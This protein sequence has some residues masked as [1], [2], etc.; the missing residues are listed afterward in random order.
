MNL[1][2]PGSLGLIACPGGE[3]FAN[4][5]LTSL[6]HIYKK[7]LLKKASS[8]AK[9]YG[10][11]KEDV[12]T[13]INFATDLHAP[14]PLYS[15]PVSGF[16]IPQFS[17]DARFTRFA[18]GEFKTELLS[19]VRGMD[20]YV[21]QDVANQHP[22]SFYNDEKKY[23]LSINDHVMILFNTVDSLLQASV[24]S[25]SVVIPVFPFA[26]QHK[27]KGREGLSA[28]WF[29]RVLEHMG[30]SRIVTLD[31]H[32]T[33]IENSFNSLRMENLHGSYQTIRRLA[34][35]VD[36]EK[37]DI[38]VVS[39]DTGAISRNKFY[40]GNLNRPLALLYKERDYSIVTQDADD[41][42]IATIRLL[43][44]VKGKKVF[45][46]DDMIGTGGTIIS[47]M[48]YLK[49]MGAE[50]IIVGVS[51][52]LFTADAIHH[53]DQAY[54]DGLF[55]RVIGTNSVFHA[56]DLLNREWYVQANVSSLFARI[57]YRLHHN[58]S[59]SRLLDN[60]GIIQHVL[61]Q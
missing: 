28:S 24:S 4:E 46:A 10:R 16:R 39:P 11:T 49:E 29:G 57:I 20:I 40:A 7:K 9:Q 32:S 38:V 19:S 37:D 2:K 61:K 33:E 53:F 43:G 22:L 56:E 55:H 3:Y 27:K 58:T 15:G 35:I 31:V 26:R 50:D 34:Q 12:M 5:V 59:L 41:S 6:K 54:A 47:A 18:N 51:L 1:S 21:I 52:P 36:L 48:K 44:S 17:V 30:V 25:V 45:M 23:R 8:L 42:N 60:S 13:Q 14:R